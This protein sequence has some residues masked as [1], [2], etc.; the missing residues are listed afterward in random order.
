MGRCGMASGEFS[1]GLGTVLVGFLLPTTCP[2]S[3]LQ[4]THRRSHSLRCALTHPRR[5]PIATLGWPVSCRCFCPQVTFSMSLNAGHLSIPNSNALF[6]KKSSSILPL[7]KYCV[8][9]VIYLGTFCHL[10]W[11]LFC[12]ALRERDI[13]AEAHAVRERTDVCHWSHVHHV[14]AQRCAVCG[15]VYTRNV[16][17]G[18]SL[19][20][21]DNSRRPPRLPL[22]ASSLTRCNR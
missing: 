2:R 13:N 20:P 4:G 11:C 1:R 19:C 3:A 9:S 8:L 12:R 16:R 10:S 6:V 15:C 18:T 22:T 14:G 5:F 7:P 17:V 21:V